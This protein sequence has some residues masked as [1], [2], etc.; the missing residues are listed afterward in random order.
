MFFS[1]FY[2]KIMPSNPMIETTISLY[3]RNGS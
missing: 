2:S 3:S 1:S